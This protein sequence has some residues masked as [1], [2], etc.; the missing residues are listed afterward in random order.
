MFGTVP[1]IQVDYSLTNQGRDLFDSLLPLF[2]YVS[3][4]QQT[5]CS[6]DP[7]PLDDDDE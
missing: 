2:N 1:P 4:L 3:R 7:P 6:S 5:N